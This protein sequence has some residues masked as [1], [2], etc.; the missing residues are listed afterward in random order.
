MNFVFLQTNFISNLLSFSFCIF[1]INESYKNE[2]CFVQTD[3][4]GICSTEYIPTGQNLVGQM[5]FQK[6][7]DMKS[8]KLNQK[9]FQFALNLPD[10]N[11]Q[12]LS[13]IE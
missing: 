7:K 6:V 9:L 11:I 12:Q 3:V 8:C 2:F 4:V 1:I 13:L 5:T 10:L